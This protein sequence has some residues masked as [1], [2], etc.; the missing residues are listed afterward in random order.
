MLCLRSKLLK[1]KIEFHQRRWQIEKKI[2]KVQK[3]DH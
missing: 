1:V 2:R 3:E